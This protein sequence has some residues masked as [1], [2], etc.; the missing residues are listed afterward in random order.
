MQGTRLVIDRT[1]DG[2]PVPPD[3]HATLDFRAIGG[4]LEVRVD[5]PY[6]AD[7]PPEAAPGSVDELYRYEVVE[8]FL[9]GEGERYLEVEL[10]PGGHYWVLQLEGYRTRI[11]SGLPIELRTQALGSRWSGIARIGASLLPRG[12]R[13][14]NAYALHG[15][16]AARRHLAA[17]PLPGDAPDFHRIDAFPRWIPPRGLDHERGW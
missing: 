17:H 8:V 14:A 9:L 16:S 13:A 3:E 7:P 15:P 12:L 2:Q 10:G 11:R 6:R 5:S 1:W 4:D